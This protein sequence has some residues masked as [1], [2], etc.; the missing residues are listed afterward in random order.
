MF[1]P[2]ARMSLR[3]A[4]HTAAPRSQTRSRVGLALGAS[5]VL[6]AYTSWRL[7]DG[8]QRIRMD[9]RV[10]PSEK[11]DASRKTLASTSA[12][13]TSTGTPNFQ[14]ELS[15][16]SESTPS[17]AP[18]PPS[19][20]DD[21]SEPV[22]A[23]AGEDQDGENGGGGGGGA[24]NP[25]TGEI[26]WDCPCLGGMAHGPCGQEFREAF[27]CFVHSEEEPKGIECVEKFKGMQNCFRE[28]PDVY[29]E[30]IMDD[31]DE[32]DGKVPAEGSSNLSDAP[33]AN[34]TPDS[35]STARTPEK[36]SI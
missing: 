4:V 17:S 20:P 15:P 5:T 18:P 8:E 24:Y 14:P 3:R 32:E 1:R 13:S 19:S 29:G 28:H 10:S 6:V 2:L 35:S 33:D 16:V 34:V 31:D 23:P 11:V 21:A 25:V 9:A 12:P 30:D 7:M 26:N 27:S 36:P 22:E